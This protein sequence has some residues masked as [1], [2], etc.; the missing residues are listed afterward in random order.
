MGSFKPY[1]E[2]ELY[3]EENLPLQA[4]S[5]S[6]ALFSTVFHFNVHGLSPASFITWLVGSTVIATP[7]IG[8]VVRSIVRGSVIQLTEHCSGATLPNNVWQEDFQVC[9]RTLTVVGFLRRDA[10]TD[11]AQRPLPGAVHTT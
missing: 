7:F 8:S 6:D 3:S 2:I 10:G 4:A 9:S 5:L 11:R 1:S